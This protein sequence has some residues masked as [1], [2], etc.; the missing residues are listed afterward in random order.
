MKSIF[1]EKKRE[2]LRELVK[3]LSNDYEYVSVLGTD[4]RGKNIIVTKY[5]T[6][7]NNSYETEKGF[8][9][10]LYKDNSYREYA[11]SNVDMAGLDNLIKDIKD[12]TEINSNFE[13]FKARKLEEEIIKKD[14]LRDKEGKVL[15]TEE[16]IDRLTDIKNELSEN[17]LLVQ[18]NISFIDTEVNKLFISTNKELSQTYCFTNCFLVCIVRKDNNV[19]YYYGDSESLSDEVAI[20]ELSKK[21]PEILDV[22]IKLLAAKPVVPG[23]YDVVTDPS[24][25]GLIAHEAFGH[26]VEMD[27]FVK[28][29]AM[30]VNYMQKQVASPLVTMHDDSKNVLSIAS[31]F[32]DDDGILAKDTVIIKNGILQAGISDATSAMELGSIPTSNGRR[33]S[34]ERKAYARMTN[35]YFEPGTSKLADIIK[36]IKHGYYLC[37]TSNGM[38]DPK[39][40][41][42]QCVALYGKEIKD[43]KFTGE[44]ISPVVMSGYVPDLLKSI[45][46][47]SDA[48]SLSGSGH[49]GKGYKEWVRV[50][51]GGACLKARVKLG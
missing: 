23:V 32:F 21:A 4:V 19:K 15:S 20:E 39:N 45:S 14:F 40:W 16:V 30:S 26:G 41:Q 38:E 11:F 28:E 2:V 34:F 18:T 17:E 1:L 6:N 46:M 7:I 27:M 43:G 10:K 31:Y 44:F 33:E 9:V 3:R 25:T 50:S 48:S 8:V 29:R 51:D 47:I 24:I 35:T 13:T 36:S 5:E 37:Q 42:I 22:A 12:S 49:C